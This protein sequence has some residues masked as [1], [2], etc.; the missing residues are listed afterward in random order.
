MF[1]MFSVY[2]YTKFT[3]QTA[4]A[5][6]RKANRDLVPRIFRSFITTQ[7]FRILRLTGADNSGRALRYEMS[8]LARK[9][10]SW[11]RIQL[12]A[13]MSVWFLFCVLCRPV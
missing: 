5:I 11:V 12:K 4:I 9:L 13:R 8:S 7:S 10:E 1:A 3:P 6:F 2:Q